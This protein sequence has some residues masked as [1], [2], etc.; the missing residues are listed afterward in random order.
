AE[1]GVFVQTHFPLI[2]NRVRAGA[3]AL[4]QLFG[5][6]MRPAYG[7]AFGEA[8]GLFFNFCANAARPLANIERVQCAPHVDHKNLAICVC[9][10]LVYGNFN[11]R[12]RCWLV[13]WEAGVIIELPPGVMIGFP[14]S[15]FYHWNVDVCDIGKAEILLTCDGSVPDH[16]RGNAK[17]LR[18]E[19]QARWNRA[20][21]RGSMVWFNQASMFQSAELGVNSVKTARARGM[22]ATCDY[23]DMIASG[24]FPK[25]GGVPVDRYA[26]ASASGAASPAHNPRGD[27]EDAHA[28]DSDTSISDPESQMP[29]E[30]R[31]RFTAHAPEEVHSGSEDMVLDSD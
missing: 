27:T 11:H 19:E 25:M 21:G 30:S 15:L 8:D 1:V 26:S 14:S 17:P 4:R 20:Y 23:E 2:A 29:M 16:A 6:D 22:D 18:D 3:Q 13:I 12:E 31:V 24:Y 28:D 9:V 10:I 7:K 5:E